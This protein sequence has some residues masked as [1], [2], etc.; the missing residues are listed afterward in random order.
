MIYKSFHKC[1][2]RYQGIFQMSHQDMSEKTVEKVIVKSSQQNLS[3]KVA[4]EGHW[5]SYKKNIVKSCWKK[6][7]K[8]H[9]YLCVCPFLRSISPFLQQTF[10]L[11]WKEQKKSSQQCFNTFLI[12]FYSKFLRCFEK[13]S[14]N[15]TMFQH[16]FYYFILTAWV[17]LYFWRFQRSL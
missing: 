11:F 12:T 9:I 14:K 5:K 1:I 13:N 15:S 2:T 10:T 7:S 17:E 6:S 8:R 16:F 3:E 4:E